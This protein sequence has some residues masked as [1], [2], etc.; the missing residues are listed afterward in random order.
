MKHR[1]IKLISMLMAMLMIAGVCT[2]CGTSSDKNAGT[3]DKKDTLT[4][5]FESEPTTLS[6]WDNE[7]M[8]SIYSN[9]MTNN[10]LMKIDPQTMEPVCDLAESYEV[11]TENSD[12]N[13]E[14]I[15]RLRKGVKFHHGKEF[16]A[17]DV[18]ATIDY[19]KKI[20]AA[21]P[22]VGAI[23]EVQKIDDYTVKFI[24]NGSYP[25]LLYDL[26]FKYCF[27]YPADLLESGHDFATE[28]AGTGPYKLTEWSKG[29]YLV[30]ERNEDYFDT[31][32][33]LQIKKIV[34]KVIPEGT[35]RTLALQT[36][37]VDLIYDV[38]S[39]DV[40]TM[41]ADDSITL[42]QVTSVENYCLCFNTDKAPFDDSNFRNAIAYAID[43]D[44]I[45][46]GALN[47]Y[48]VTNGTSIALGYWGSYTGGA[49]THDVDK[50]REYLKAWGGDPA[51]VDM[52][53]LCWSETLVRV[54]TII[55]GNLSE[56]G[57]N[58]KVVETDTAT[59][60]SQRASGDYQALISYWSPSNAFN[61]ITRYHSSRRA[62]VPGACNDSLVDDLVEMIKVTVNDDGRLELINKC[63]AR[64]NEI[65]VQP[66]LYQPTT[67]RAYNSK[68]AGL[69]FSKNGYFDFTGA[70][71]KE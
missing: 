59:M 21:N 61:Y 9:Y 56:I 34:W 52:S 50:A 2:G 47:G 27:I 30:Y 53:I 3:E 71:W 35:S 65:A 38:E 60:S 58:A 13:A 12:G 5:A 10:F 54:G 26:G 48:G 11:V 39:Y 44:S 7:E 29:S 46:Q 4:I 66:S 28:P 64:V 40:S 62:S 37:E 69:K 63:V 18:I 49:F 33:F 45:V 19:V 55:Q 14:Y 31:D 67:F 1:S 41:E 16:K 20:P 68:L 23:L 22:Y 32:N 51:A 57:I 36:G 15:F 25:N 6:I 43:R 42:E 24:M 70:Y 8:A 17:E